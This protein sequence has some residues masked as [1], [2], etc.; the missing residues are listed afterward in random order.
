MDLLAGIHA[1]LCTVQDA[2]SAI[3]FALLPHMPP[4]CTLG[5]NK[6]L[7]HTRM[8]TSRASKPRGELLAA[9]PAALLTAHDAESMI[10]VTPP[11]K[12]P[13]AFTLVT[14]PF[15]MAMDRK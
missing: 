2:A 7:W 8:P 6:E 4:A 10:P 14:E 9:H 13:S 15:C 11:P 12:V 1:A 3:L 5:S